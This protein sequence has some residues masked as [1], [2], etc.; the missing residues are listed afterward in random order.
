M[1]TSPTAGGTTY[2]DFGR[3][4]Q[5]Y[6]E[7]PD[8]VKK[9][10]WGCLFYFLAMFLV[11]APF[12]AGYGAEV[13]RRAARGEPR[14]LPEWE[15]FGQFFLEG[16]L[17][18]ALYLL[19]FLAAAILPGSLGCLFAVIGSAASNNDAAAGVASLGVMVAVLLFVAVLVAVMLYFPAAYLRMVVTG[20]F[21]AGFEV[22]ENIDLIK[23]GPG[24]LPHGDRHLHRHVRDLVRAGH[25]DLPHR[26]PSVRLLVGV[27]RR[28]GHWARWRG[29]TRCWAAVPATR[30]CSPDRGRPRK[31][32][33][34]APDFRDTGAIPAGAA[35]GAAHPQ[36]A[37]RPGGRADGRRVRGRRPGG[38]GRRHRAGA[39][40]EEGQG[41]GRRRSATSR[42]PCW[43]RP[44]RWARTACRARW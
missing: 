10:L 7:D 44:R 38:A 37:A 15:N 41:G 42:S 19:H 8:W 39:A 1:A 30:T 4:F 23:R 28:A 18:I 24:Q 2:V 31:I 35:L 11:G 5:F 22:R 13:T 20:R 36:G 40:G 12:L 34:R 6:F 27:R 32:D 43:R 16:L 14:P 29:A 17:V 9:T 33:E 26:E 3:A 21:A 25:R